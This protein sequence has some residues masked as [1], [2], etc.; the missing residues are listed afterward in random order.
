MEGKENEK[1]RKQTYICMIIV[2]L[3]AVLVGLYLV[4]DGFHSFS[5]YSDLWHMSFFKSVM[6]CI[7]D[8]FKWH[9]GTLL[10]FSIV[11]GLIIDSVIYI[12][13]GIRENKCVD[14]PMDVNMKNPEEQERKNMNQDENI[15]LKGDTNDGKVKLVI[16]GCFIVLEL[17]VVVLAFVSGDIEFLFNL[18][19]GN[20]YLA[21]IS[22]IVLRLFGG[23]IILTNKEVYGKGV[24]GF[25]L[26]KPKDFSMDIQKIKSAKVC[27]FKG[28]E[29]AGTAGS[30]KILFVKNNVAMV[31]E[32]VEMINTADGAKYRLY[33]VNG[34]MFV[35][36]NKVVIE[37]K[38]VLGF[39]SQGK[40]GSKTIPM[41][42]IMSVQF[43]PSSGLTNG[44]IQF[45]IMG[46]KEASG[47][48]F[49]ATDDENTIMVPEEYNDLAEEIAQF[50]ENIILNRGNG[51]G[52]TVV[53]QQL[54]S[55]DELK[56]FK[57][58]LD[59]GVIT[60]EEFDAKKKQLLGL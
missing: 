60:Q 39:L 54:S 9:H 13:G 2:L 8:G 1:I 38:G 5:Y 16:T 44:F 20:L 43:Q 18:I 48:I 28:V 33:G 41:N 59:M 49:S 31:E 51:G 30:Y 37:R 36:D 55:A 6:N 3:G 27:G 35:F 58:L 22:F 4:A 42:S 45:G 17:I 26:G 56:K 34:Q 15:V 32:I 14:E 40:A 52:T 25:I 7:V 50:V 12:V 11:F 29:V 21:L 47:G 53:Q 46:G 10:Y 57:D 24:M 19:P 23:S